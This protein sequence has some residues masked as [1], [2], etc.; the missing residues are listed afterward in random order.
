MKARTIK[1]IYINKREVF[2]GIEINTGQEKVYAS[3]D[4]GPVF[5]KDKSVIAKKVREFNRKHRFTPYP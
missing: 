5:D 4:N 3:D 1:W 2:Y